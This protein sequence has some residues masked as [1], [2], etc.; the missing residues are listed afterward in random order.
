MRNVSKDKLSKKELA[1]LDAEEKKKKALKYFTAAAAEK[2]KV[3]EEQQNRE[4]IRRRWEEFCYFIKKDVLK[5]LPETSKDAY[6]LFKAGKRA[7]K[8]KNDFFKVDL[9]APENKELKEDLKKLKMNVK[10]FATI[11]FCATGK[12]IHKI[13][14]FLNSRSKTNTPKKREEIEAIRSRS[15]NEARE[16][17]HNHANG[18]GKKLA[19]ILYEGIKNS[20]KRF[21]DKTISSEEAMEY[22][23]HVGEMLHLMERDP[24][25]VKESGIT[26]RQLGIAYIASNMGKNIKEGLEN[27]ELLVK[28]QQE[29]AQLEQAQKNAI[30]N[31]IIQMKLALGDRARVIGEW[32][33]PIFGKQKEEPKLPKEPV[34]NLNLKK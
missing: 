15:I 20:C 11:A 8:L 26:E 9:E 33:E 34:L 16:A 30:N 29:G 7:I 28:L 21:A 25:L 1:E 23:M 3:E 13:S 2:Q 24:K 18:N 4:E 31:S 22:S 32:D 12:H 17:I 14:D 19:K 6:E 5:T 10:N 27:V